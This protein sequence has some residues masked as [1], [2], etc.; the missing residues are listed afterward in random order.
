VN[1]WCNGF[2][3]NAVWQGYAYSI[4]PG[5]STVNAVGYCDTSYYSYYPGVTYLYTYCWLS[6]ISYS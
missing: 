3:Q 2:Q 5:T 1:T 6:S 4:V